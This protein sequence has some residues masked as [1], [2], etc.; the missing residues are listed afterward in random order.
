MVVP[1]CHYSSSQ[2][3]GQ[4]FLNLRFHIIELIQHVV[5]TVPDS[6]LLINDEVCGRNVAIGSTHLIKRF[7]G[8]IIQNERIG[9]AS[10]GYVVFK[11]GYRCGKINR[12]DGQ[13]IRCK[14]CPYDPLQRRQL[15]LDAVLSGVLEKDEKNHFSLKA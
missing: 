10:L 3:R 12:H 5:R 9:K 1:F 4:Q 11:P 7:Y 8:T 14:I 15:R 2:R 6:S 13:L